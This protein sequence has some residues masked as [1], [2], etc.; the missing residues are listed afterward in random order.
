MIDLITRLKQAILENTKSHIRIIIWDGERI[1]NIFEIE[2]DIGQFLRKDG[3]IRAY[4][5]DEFRRCL[6]RGFRFEIDGCD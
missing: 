1:D 3:T 4:F 2:S 6:G 5:K